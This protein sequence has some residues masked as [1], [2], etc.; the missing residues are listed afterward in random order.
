MR[1]LLLIAL[2]ACSGSQSG[3]LPV[4]SPARPSEPPQVNVPGETMSSKHPWPATRVAAVSDT[5]HGQRIADPYRWL[6]DAESPEVQSWMTEQDRFARAE[7]ARLA[8]RDPIAE[9]LKQLFYF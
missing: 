8:Q 1:K 2:V 7:L 4:E 5:L 3:R 6:E 9:R